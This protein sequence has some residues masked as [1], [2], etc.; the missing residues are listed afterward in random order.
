[1]HHILIMDMGV[2]IYTME[3]KHMLQVIMKT[4]QVAQ[5]KTKQVVQSHPEM[6]LLL[7]LIPIESVLLLIDPIRD[8]ALKKVW[9]YYIIRQLA[10]S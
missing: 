5:M 9:L 4:K 3:K 6:T 2:T 7:V 10:L 1:M 8:Q